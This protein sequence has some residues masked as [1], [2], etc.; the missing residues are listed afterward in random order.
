M[1]MIR[2]LISIIIVLVWMIQGASAQVLSGRETVLFDFDWKFTKGAIAGAAQSD[3]ND[4]KWRS[5]NLPHDWSIEDL[6]NYVDEDEK[7]INLSEGR[8]KFIRGDNMAYKE[9]RAFEGNWDIVQVP[10]NWQIYPLPEAEPHWGWYRRSVNL[11]EEDRFK[12]I[13]I[14]LGKIG[15]A[16]EL[17]FNGKLVGSSGQMPPGFISAK[18]ED[19]VYLIPPSAINYNGR[20]VVALR[21]YSESG[22][23]GIL[24][25]KPL[26]VIS[27]PFDSYSE[28][29][30]YTA[31]TL[32]GVG[33]YRKTFH[34]SENELNRAF[35]IKFDGVYKETEVWFNGH[36]LP[37]NYSGYSPFEYDITEWIR[38]GAD[39]VLAVRVRNG[40]LNSRW[41][42]GS[43][44]YRHVWLIKS[45]KIFH[46][47]RYTKMDVLR[48]D[49]KSSAINFVAGIKNITQDTTLLKWRVE[50]E[51]NLGNQLAVQEKMIN[52][53]S[54]GSHQFSIRF[55]I[56]STKLWHPDDPT[57]YTI[58]SMLFS[59]IK[60]M[61]GYEN[62]LGI[63]RVE[64][65]A[66]KGMLLNGEPIVLKGGNLHHDN[67]ALGAKSFDE[68]E[69]RKVRLLKQAGYNAIWTAHNPASESLLK[70]C[71]QL[72]MMVVE[73]A[74]DVWRKGKLAQDYHTIFDDVWKRDIKAMV[75]RDR[76]HPSVIMWS[77]GNDV[78]ERFDPGINTF[79]ALIKEEIH[80]YDTSR[81]VTAGFGKSDLEW[82]HS[83]PFFSVL[84]VAGYNYNYEQYFVDRARKP[85]RIMVGSASYPN[86]AWEA[87]EAVL[88]YPYVVGDFVWSAFD[89]LGESAL[90]WYSKENEPDLLYPWTTAYCGDFDIA[91]GLRP[92]GA[93][94]K[95]LWQTKPE[96]SLYIKNPKPFYEERTRM[97]WGWEDV[98][99]SWTWPGYEKLFFEAI[100]YTN[101]EEVKLFSNGME[102]ATKQLSPAMQNRVSF[103]LEYNPGTIVAIGINNKKTQITST[104]RTAEFPRVIHLKA[105]KDEMVANGQDLVY[106][107]VEIHDG[108]GVLN[109]NYKIPLN[110]E[111]TGPGEIIGIGNG[112]PQN[113][114]SFQGPVKSTHQGRCQ[115][116]IRS[117]QMPGTLN[118]KVTD[119]GKL[120]PGQISIKSHNIRK[121]LL[122]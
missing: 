59:G 29:G 62:S 119:I 102:I 35:R 28:G 111:L 27:G 96:L 52:V 121:G 49:K 15:D 32:G 22:N 30:R 120:I 10:A 118:L 65:S 37:S 116:I 55:N 99:P 7:V 11:S 92:Q 70:A 26:R 87:W 117:K 114:E 57:L 107:D 91:G 20:N 104:L 100:V 73:E 39:N 9:Y 95:T 46:D 72:G 101:C 16:D 82:E 51:D 64:F 89:Y 58:R 8:W 42:A 81:P 76:N 63:R 25:K 5:V 13:S 108:N 48:V 115:V 45:E 1:A 105:S 74:F 86:H 122:W 31:Y 75:L 97:D 84:D 6:P 79:A 77:I 44:I 110:F 17:Y 61:D 94:R 98:V 4:N 34:I 2:T 18:N 50:L 24:Q 69:F 83:D 103:L 67:G 38:P 23:G 106:V 88:K 47:D 78:E 71:D 3:F 85:H 21:V 12:N 53:F 68:A 36:K 19:R 80:K 90:G 56:D 60:P 109:P 93:Y 54:G 43:G 14:Q 33:W 113:T 66:E 40:G 41:Y 112:D